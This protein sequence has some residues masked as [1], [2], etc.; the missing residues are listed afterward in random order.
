MEKTKSPRKQ[1]KREKVVLSRKGINVHLSKELRAKY[2]LRT[3]GLRK[4]DEV[5]V[6]RGKFKGKVGKVEKIVPKKAKVFIIRYN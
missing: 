2:K 5:K 4:G 1:R 6:M 3:F